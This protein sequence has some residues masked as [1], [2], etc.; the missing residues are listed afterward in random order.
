MTIQQHCLKDVT[1]KVLVLSKI[2][3]LKTLKSIIYQK[4]VKKM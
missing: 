3:G 4:S 1:K 2:A